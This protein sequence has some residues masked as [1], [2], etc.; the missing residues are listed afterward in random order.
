MVLGLMPIKQ[1]GSTTAGRQGAVRSLVK[2]QLHGTVL[3]IAL[4]SFSL[5]TTVESGNPKIGL[6]SLLLTKTG[7]ARWVLSTQTITNMD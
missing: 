3:A 5:L 6:L 2:Q 7:P 4:I 1:M